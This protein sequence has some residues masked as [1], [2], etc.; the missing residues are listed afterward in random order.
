MVF[1]VLAVHEFGHLLTG[2]FQG[3]QLQFF[4]IGF[5][6]IKRKDSNSI[7]QI[8]GSIFLKKR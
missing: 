7:T 3:F 2:L 4:V 8:D 6:G 1:L 5:L